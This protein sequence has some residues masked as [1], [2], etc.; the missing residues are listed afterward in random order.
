MPLCLFIHSKLWRNSRL[1]L[2][3]CNLFFSYRSPSAGLTIFWLDIQ[4][5]QSCRT[6]VKHT[7]LHP[8]CI[9]TLMHVL[10]HLVERRVIVCLAAWTCSWSMNVLTSHTSG[11]QLLYGWLVV[12]LLYRSTI[13]TDTLLHIP[14]GLHTCRQNYMSWMSNAYEKICIKMV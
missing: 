12:K 6:L 9:S 4:W 11:M 7:C 8:S 3:C 5:P 13:H 1:W 10:E 2:I 14:Q